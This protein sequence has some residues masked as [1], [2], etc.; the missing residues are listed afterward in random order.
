MNL[1]SWVFSVAF[2]L[3]SS[4]NP[5]LK[6]EPHPRFLQGIWSCP[7]VA[8]ALRFAF[9]AD[10]TYTRWS[11]ADA[12]SDDIG[13][14]EHGRWEF[15]DGTLVFYKEHV[16]YLPGDGRDRVATI[17]W[18]QRN[19]NHSMADRL[20]RTDRGWIPVADED[21]FVAVVK[22]KEA[23]SHSFRMIHWSST[24]P[25]GEHDQPDWQTQCSRQSP[26]RGMPLINGI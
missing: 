17:Q 23:S 3:T 6:P 21:V 9:D 11:V 20:A 2:F 10:G 4:T 24:G 5:P 16:Y 13:L 25:E 19:G 18:L 12:I 15:V 14:G 8:G 26:T 1:R 7:L 22:V